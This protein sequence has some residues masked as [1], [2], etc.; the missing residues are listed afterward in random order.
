MG[1]IPL[2]SHLKLL[3]IVHPLSSANLTNP[4]LPSDLFTGWLVMKATVVYKPDSFALV[5]GTSSE[6]PESYN[7]VNL[8]GGDKF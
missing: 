3:A 6:I 8:L 1:S 4:G 7:A 5:F 2:R